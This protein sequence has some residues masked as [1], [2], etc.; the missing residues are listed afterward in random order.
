MSDQDVK[1]WYAKLSGPPTAPSAKVFDWS[2]LD[3][4]DVVD[5]D[6]L[7]EGPSIDLLDE[8]LWARC[9]RS[10]TIIDF[11]PQVVERC[12]VMLA[13]LEID[14]RLDTGDF[15]ALP[16]ASGLFDVVLDFSS[17]DHVE[18]NR[19][20]CR[21][22][23]FRVLRR[24]GIYVVTYADRCYYDSGETRDLFGYEV[25][26]RPDELSDELRSAGFAIEKK[27]HLIGG[28]RSG[29]VARRP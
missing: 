22:E 20:L 12:R 11:T 19:Q 10:W 3:E 17:S 24:D 14:A 28:K 5:G 29:I 23:A 2:V 21:S 9:A 15:R 18:E 26:L 4:R 13:R 6:V 25:R 16:Y 8:A 7:N 1:D 27:S